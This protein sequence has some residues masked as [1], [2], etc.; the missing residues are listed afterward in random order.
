MAVDATTRQL[1]LQVDASVELAR[2]NLNL[3][4]NDVQKQAASM[5]ASLSRIDKATDRISHGF[6][7][8]K[9]AAVGLI[10]GLGV[11]E[12]LQAASAGLDYAS[13]LGE[14]SQQIGVSTRD[15]QVYR[16]AATQVGVAQDEM[17]AGLRKLT[18][19]IGEA[20]AGSE[21]PVNAFREIGVSVTDANGK[22]LTAG[23]IIPRIADG[24]AKI[25]DPATRARIEVDLFGKAGQ[26]LDTLLAG[27]SSAINDLAKQADELG[28]VLSDRLIQQ[29]DDAA[30]KVAVLKKV[31]EAQ[32]AGA[33]AENADNISY[34]ADQLFRVAGAA[35]EAAANW[36]RWQT[37]M[38]RDQEIKRANSGY[39]HVWGIPG[40]FE[41][42]RDTR[43]PLPRGGGRVRWEGQA[44]R[45][46]LPEPPTSGELPTVKPK[47][48][49]RGRGKSGRTGPSLSERFASLEGNLDAE[50]GAG[51]DYRDALALID[52]AEKAGLSAQSSF[53]DL[54]RAAGKNLMQD[55]GI[56]E[57]P[58]LV[59][60]ASQN[61]DLLAGQI[62]ELPEI[63]PP[64][65]MQRLAE[66]EESFTRD[67]AA[68]LA[69]A[70]IYGD[71]LGDV[72]ENSF[73]RAAAALVESGLMELINPGGSGGSLFRG[74]LSGSSSLFSGLGF[75]NGGTPP[76]GKISVVGERGPELFIPKVPGVVVP[77]HAL[78]GG[79]GGGGSQLVTVQID[80][81]A[82][83]DTHVRV[84][85]APLA[86]A[87][88]ARGAAGGASMAEQR[89]N[90]R[91]MQTLR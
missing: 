24:L 18:R 33:V 52:A 55:L 26:K 67:L 90:R 58:I 25:E 48:P 84:A 11:A 16:Y 10:A 6:G 79:W 31:L 49:S 19:T 88:A 30:D 17:D 9:G 56:E 80:K 73:K 68:G 2:R 37:Q 38:N 91:A 57:L 89:L 40:L 21:G 59:L 47:A 86:A 76:V 36:G 5:D 75:A 41:I 50:A 20:A 43:R 60:E 83:F 12:F 1:L 4:S 62:S 61:M 35:A 15:L 78:M 69:D 28:L 44:D 34:L 27:G 32:I 22:L 42:G 51:K 23:E 3:L 81:S 77:N 87:A 53:A 64:E 13:S 39:E 63:I 82:L 66:F 71:N 29:A 14:V 54:R 7:L 45:P 72:L 46:T 85:A 65:E 74:F 8:L 70:A